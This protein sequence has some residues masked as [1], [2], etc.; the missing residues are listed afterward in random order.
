MLKTGD[1]Y[2]ASARERT[3]RSRTR[4]ATKVIRQ[5]DQVKIVQF[6]I[7]FRLPIISIRRIS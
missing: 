5:E 1:E 7:T 2:R 4:N 3:R 6:V